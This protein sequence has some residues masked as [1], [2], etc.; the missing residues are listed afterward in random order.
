[1]GS[2]LINALTVFV[3]MIVFFTLLA[4]EIVFSLGEVDSSDTLPS[5]IKIDDMML[6]ASAALKPALYSLIVS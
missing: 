5:S 2:K 6:T 4:F 3:S 1:M